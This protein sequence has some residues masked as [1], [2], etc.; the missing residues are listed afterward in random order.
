ME[1]HHI[2]FKSQGGLDFPLNYKILTPEDHRGNKGPH[3]CRSKDLDYKLELEDN[4]F[5]ILFRHFYSE[6]Q[7]INIL[8]LKPAQAH[9]ICKKFTVHKEGFAREDVIRRLLGGKIY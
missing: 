5:S 9:K 7:L 1:K 3:L 8:Q 2:I 4:L 6:H